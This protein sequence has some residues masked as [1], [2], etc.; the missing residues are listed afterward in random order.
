MLRQIIYQSRINPAGP[1]TDLRELLRKAQQLNAI[2][3]ITGLLYADGERFLQVLEGPD[4]SV[5]ATYARIKHDSRHHRIAK[6]GDRSIDAR[7]FGDWSMAERVTRHERDVFDQRMRTAL[8]EASDETRGWFEAL[9]E[10]A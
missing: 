4:E 6:E 9:I 7:E 3:G 8:I 1:P 10:S 5:Q 2:D